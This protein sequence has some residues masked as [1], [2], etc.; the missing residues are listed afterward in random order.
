[1]HEKNDEEELLKQFIS[2]VT[3]KGKASKNNDQ[4]IGTVRSAKGTDK[5]KLNFDESTFSAIVKCLK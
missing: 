1:M 4:A 3:T 5:G 2:S